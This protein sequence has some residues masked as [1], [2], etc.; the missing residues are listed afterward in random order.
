MKVPVARSSLFLSES[1]SCVHSG[2]LI[3][4]FSGRNPDEASVGLTKNFLSKSNM[5]GFFGTYVASLSFTSHPHF[6]LFM[7]LWC[8]NSL[9]RLDHWSS[10]FSITWFW[11]EHLSASLV[12]GPFLVL[13]PGFNAQDSMYVCLDVYIA[14][15]C[16]TQSWEVCFVL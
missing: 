16:F 5:W 11:T 13:T 9:L 7:N 3:Y 1:T 2:W 4:H 12:S 8:S 15:S 10:F 14:V 6:L